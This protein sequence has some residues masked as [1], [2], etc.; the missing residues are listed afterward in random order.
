MASAL[1]HIDV[2]FAVVKDVGVVQQAQSIKQLSEVQQMLFLHLA[3]F[4]C[5]ELSV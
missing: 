2:H 3:D 5:E 1:S 4:H